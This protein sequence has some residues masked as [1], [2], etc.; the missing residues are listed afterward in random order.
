MQTA[1]PP[2]AKHS[3][4]APPSVQNAGHHQPFSPTTQR[5]HLLR[6]HPSLALH[7]SVLPISHPQFFSPTTLSTLGFLPPELPRLL[8][9]PLDWIS[10]SGRILWMNQPREHTSSTLMADGDSPQQKVTQ[11]GYKLL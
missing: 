10:G 5:F 3:S 6:H 7:L 2:H 1:V 8:L 4:T 11:N 9:L